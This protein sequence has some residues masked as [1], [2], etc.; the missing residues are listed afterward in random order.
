M[1][2]HAQYPSLRKTLSRPLPQR[3]LQISQHISISARSIFRSTNHTVALTSLS[4][5][6]GST[7]RILYPSSSESVAEERLAMGGS[8]SLR[9]FGY[10]SELGYHL[11]PRVK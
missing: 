7:C 2:N 11:V 5:G 10:L 4:T 8:F 1:Q 3:T 9:R 6:G